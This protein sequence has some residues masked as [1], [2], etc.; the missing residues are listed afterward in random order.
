[1]DLEN[2]R[3]YTPDYTVPYKPKKESL[4]FLSWCNLNLVEEDNKT[5]RMHYEMLDIVLSEEKRVQAIVHRGGAKTTLLNTKMALY[6]A[7]LGYMPNFKNKDGEEQQ[8]KN[9]MIFSGSEEQAIGL[10]EEIVFMWENSEVL[11]QTLT[12][13]KATKKNARFKNEKGDVIYMQVKGSGQSLRGTKRAGKRPQLMMFDDILPDD[14]LFSKTERMKVTK[15]FTSSV[16]PAVDVNF[17]KMIVVGTPFAED[18]I[19]MKM[20]KGKAYMT[21]FCPVA[22]KFPV[23]K[24]DIVSSWADRFTQDEIWNLYEG[25]KELNE[26]ASFYREYMLQVTSEETRTFKDKWLKYYNYSDLK[27]RLSELNFFTSLDIAVSTKTSGDYRVI[28]TIGVDKDK[29]W[30]LVR[31][32]VGHYNPSEIIDILFSH[33]KQYR[34]LETRAEKASLQQVLDHFIQLQMHKT[35]TYFNY[36]GLV[37]NSMQGKEFRITALQP[38]FKTGKIWFPSDKD[39]TSLAELDYEYKGYTKEG[40]T[41]PHDDAL[42]CL[43]NFLDPDFIVYPTDDRGTEVGGDEFEFGEEDDYTY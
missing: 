22:H 11:Q 9:M 18:D 31:I 8:I 38:M 36:D 43:A 7:S 33:V 29:N 16:Q 21:I 40:P 26:E 2:S 41:T 4:D 6:V 35:G 19:L 20:K 32:D 17:N 13:E 15:W 39:Q 37:N 10:L 5:P 23:A 25:A 14:A 24:E 28:M 3:V 30:F 42:D 27:P 12:L 1:M 34:P